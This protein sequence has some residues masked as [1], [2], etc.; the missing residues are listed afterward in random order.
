MKE[1]RY[2][3]PSQEEAGRAFVMRG[4]PPRPA[5]ACEGS[6]TTCSRKLRSPARLSAMSYEVATIPVTLS[7]GSTRGVM[8]FRKSSYA[9]TRQ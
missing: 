9:R 5:R 4:E 6:S 1:S 8:P 2:L 7:S 3:E